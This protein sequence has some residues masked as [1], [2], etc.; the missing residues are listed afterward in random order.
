MTSRLHG[1]L[2]WW[3]LLLCAVSVAPTGCKAL[4]LREADETEAASDAS[5]SES[6]SDGTTASQTADLSAMWNAA[7]A[8]PNWVQAT[9]K[10]SPH[11]WRHALIDAEPAR[12]KEKTTGLTSALRSENPLVRANAA[13]ALARSGDMASDERL[14]AA[15]RERQ[16]PL[17]LRQAAAE[18]LGRSTSPAARQSVRE[19]LAEYGRFGEEFKTQYLPELHAE[20]VHAVGTTGKASD[21]AI[22]AAL[23]CPSA[24]PRLEAARCWADD[25]A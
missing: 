15:I 11:R 10:S 1:H 2:A 8:D 25:R 4:R 3:L 9:G 21:P 12:D 23:R 20:L 14:V 17:P 6:D 13:I 24:L 7:L 22:V 16:L 18:A 5:A 19:L